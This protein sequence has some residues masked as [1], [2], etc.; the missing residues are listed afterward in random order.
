VLLVTGFKSGTDCE[1]KLNRVIIFYVAAGKF[2][3]HGMDGNTVEGHTI[4]PIVL[5]EMLFFNFYQ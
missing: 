1:N 2:S 3:E 4:A 5:I